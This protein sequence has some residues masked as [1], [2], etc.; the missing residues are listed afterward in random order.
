MQ[1]EVKALSSDNQII[2][3]VID[4]QDENDARRQLEARGLHATRLVPQRSLRLPSA[5]RG[6][7]S[8]VLFSQ[9]LLALLT[10]KDR[11]STRLNSSH[12]VTSRMPSSA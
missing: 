12:V 7:L 4:A 11:K 9:E 6:G 1:Y 2:A 8:L 3:L 5:S 10:A